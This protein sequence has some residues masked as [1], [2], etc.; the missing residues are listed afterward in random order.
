MGVGIVD[1]GFLFYCGGKSGYKNFFD[2]IYFCYKD[3]Y[4]LKIN[5]CSIRLEDL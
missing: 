3:I 1:V 5:E 2:F 4:F